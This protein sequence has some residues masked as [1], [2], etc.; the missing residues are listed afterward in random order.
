[1]YLSGGRDIG[2]WNGAQLGGTMS[3][4]VTLMRR[5]LV[6]LATLALLQGC[7]SLEHFQQGMDSRLGW[8]IDQLRAYFG[9]NYIERD[10]GDGERAYTWTWAEHGMRPGYISPD[11]IHTYQSARGTQVSVTPG[12]YFPPDYYAYACEFTYIVDASGRATAWRAHG[13][14][15]AAYPGPEQLQQRG[16][17]ADGKP[18]LD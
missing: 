2:N 7:A 6:L 11:V 9:Y 10:L 14:G 4:E 15:C 5:Y 18:S 8:D 1:M 17:G 12:T 16:L 13:N 3:E